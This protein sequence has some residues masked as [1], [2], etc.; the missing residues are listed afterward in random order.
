[1]GNL[2]WIEIIYWAA[3]IF[4]GTLFILRTILFLVGGGLDG[5]DYDTGLA[6]ALH[7]EIMADAMHTDV[8]AD[9]PQTA[10]MGDLH[11][12]V[13]HDGLTSSDV[14]HAAETDISFQLLSLQG[15]TAFFMMFGL[16][17]LAL[18]KANLFVPFT[19]FGAIL[20][21]LFTV[22]VIGILF[23]KMTRL[24]ADGTID[25]T[26]AVGQSGSV[27]LNIPAKGTGQVQVTIQGSLKIVDAVASEGRKLSTGEKVRVTGVSDTKTLIVEKIQIHNEKGETS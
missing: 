23:S 12:D 24:Q 25:I 4:G 11:V 21:G 20:G 16:V 10:D 5:H 1:M 3:A 14:H 22:W 27:Y 18:Y 15:L 9:V 13:D 8:M 26:N 2:S 19:V 6:D 17:G 7:T